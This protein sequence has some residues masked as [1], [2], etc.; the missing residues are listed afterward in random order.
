MGC[1]NKQWGRLQ[2]YTKEEEATVLVLSGMLLTD[3]DV[4][5][6]FSSIRSLLQNGCRRLVISLDELLH[7]GTRA[8]WSLA[9]INE[10]VKDVGGEL[11][12]SKLKI[13]DWRIDPIA[14]SKLRAT[15]QIF[16]TEKEATESFVK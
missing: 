2:I 12:L 13:L 14:I 11:R 6:L 1:H 9:R 16:D 8:T 10:E 3:E 15:F 4:A 5:I 7:M